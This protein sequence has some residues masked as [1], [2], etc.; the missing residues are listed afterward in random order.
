MTAYEHV[1]RDLRDAI[2]RGDY[3]PGDTIPRSVDLAERYGLS[4]WTIRQAIALLEREGLV[5]PVR[6]RGTVVRDRRAVRIPWSVYSSA[7]APGPRGPWERACAALGV[8]GHAELVGIARQGAPPDVAAALALAEG[9]PVVC[10]RRHMWAR[11]QVAQVQAAWYPLELVDGTP[12]AGD[13]KIV[14]GAYGALAA[15]GLAP[16]SA[17]VTVTARPPTLD[18]RGILGLGVGSPVLVVD[19]VTRDQRGRAVEFLR[20]VAD[21]DRVALVYD[22]LPVGD[23]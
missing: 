2:L 8:D 6:R 9:A 21:A 14:G 22:A 16:A 7:T 13:T 18:E 11:D 4:R 1:A 23:A 5:T 17:D 10:R 3:A 12:L 15:A 19:R 20:A